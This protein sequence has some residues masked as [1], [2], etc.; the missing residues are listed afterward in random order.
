MNFYQCGPQ[1]TREN[2]LLELTHQIIKEACFDQLRTKEQ[3]GYVV[4]CYV[5]RFWSGQGLAI[6]VQSEKSP[7]HLDRRVESLSQSE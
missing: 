6:T 2:M 7:D 4:S 5:R 1:D 3:L